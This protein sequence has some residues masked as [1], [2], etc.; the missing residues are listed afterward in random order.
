MKMISGLTFPTNGNITLFGKDIQ[1]VD[2]LINRM[3][4]LI[5]EPGLYPHLTAAQNLKIKCLAL[6]V[7]NVDKE[8]PYLLDLVDL[9]DAGKKKVKNFSLGMKQ[10]LGIAIALINHPDLLLLDEPINGL[11]PQGIMEIRELFLKL[12]RKKNI[13]ILIS[14]HILEELSK[15]AT[16]YGILDHG[17]L[18]EELTSSELLNKCNDAIR[19]VT[20]D[21]ERACTVIDEM[22][23]TNY[24]V[25][26]KET[27]E[28]YERLDE[29][30]ALNMA[31]SK[32]GILVSSVSVIHQ[33]LED[34]FLK[35]TGGSKNV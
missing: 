3:G 2:S 34:Y 5:E 19:L 12:N 15:L 29:S 23:F 32:K 26:D 35:L 4:V 1:D 11:D 18:I 27:I 16:D 17:V 7:Q 8:I 21:S 14:S 9:Q 20:N 13:T 31:L 33:G 22:G 10:R 28:I 24:K 25:I 6:G 30:A